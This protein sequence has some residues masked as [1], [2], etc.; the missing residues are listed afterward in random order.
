MEFSSTTDL[1][2]SIISFVVTCTLEYV[3]PIFEDNTVVVTRILKGRVLHFYEYLYIDIC[4]NLVF[5]QIIPISY[6]TEGFV[7]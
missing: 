1:T 4:H 3:L 6:H 5:A 2:K 7:K